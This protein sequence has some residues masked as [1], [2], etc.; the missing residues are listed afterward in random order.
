MFGGDNIEIILVGDTF[1]EAD[2][3]IVVDI[4]SVSSVGSVATE[5]GVQKVT[6]TI[7]DDDPTPIVTWT[8][9]DPSVGEGDGTPTSVSPIPRINFTVSV[10]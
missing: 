8:S 7:L 4:L 1:D 2:E 10:A 9:T 5:N 6:A 3:T